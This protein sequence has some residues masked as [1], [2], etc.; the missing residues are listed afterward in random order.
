MKGTIYVKLYLRENDLKMIIWWVDAS[1]GIH[2]D[3][4]IQNSAVILIG[5]G[6]IISSSRQ[7]NLKTN[8][9]IEAELVGTDDALGMIMF[10]KH[11]MEAQGYSIDITI[12][13]QD[14]Q[15]NI[16]LENN[17][18]SLAGKKSKH[19]TNRYFLITDQLHQEALE[20][21]YKPTSEMMADYQ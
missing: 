14:N 1:Y 12:L 21:C 4:K 18:R 19:I 9:S 7:Q 10:T 6:A 2:W 13:F 5:V 8:S 11:F 15:S 3:C 20:I 16:M 17:G